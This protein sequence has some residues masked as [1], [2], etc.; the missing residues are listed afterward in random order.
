MTLADKK[1]TTLLF[2]IEGVGAVFVIIFLAA[3]LGRH[4]HHQRSAEPTCLQG[5]PSLS[6]AHYS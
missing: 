3:Y 1:L 6:S 5:F 2:S 4:T